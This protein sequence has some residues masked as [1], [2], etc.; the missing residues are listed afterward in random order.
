MS[1]SLW[2]HTVCDSF[3]NSHHCE[4]WINLTHTIVASVVWDRDDTTELGKSLSAGSSQAQQAYMHHAGHW[5][6]KAQ[7][8]KCHVALYIWTTTQL[9]DNRLS[10]TLQGIFLQYFVALLCDTTVLLQKLPPQIEIQN[11]WAISLFCSTALAAVVRT[12]FGLWEQLE[13]LEMDSGLGFAPFT[14]LG[15]MQN[16]TYF[17]WSAHTSERL[18]CEFSFAY[19]AHFAKILKTT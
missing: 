12:F 17:S 19:S 8:K 16:P 3:C 11:P 7:K 13:T 5:R 15:G 2:Q 1:T 18:L 14:A 9:W 6:N 4:P 10:R